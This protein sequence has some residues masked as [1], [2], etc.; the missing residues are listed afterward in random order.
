MIYDGDCMLCNS[1]IAYIIRQN[2][3]D[4]YFSDFHSEAAKAI[5]YERGIQLERFDTIYYLEN[6]EFHTESTAILKIISQKKG[7]SLKIICVVL[8]V[9]PKSVRD[10]AYRLISRNRKQ[11]F[12]KDSCFLP[13]PEQRSRILVD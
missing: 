11:L 7:F 5:L 3:P 2:I 6:G 10:S 4:L 9:V 13:T 12:R 8:R 1:F